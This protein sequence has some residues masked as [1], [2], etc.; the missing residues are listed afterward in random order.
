MLRVNIEIA[1]QLRCVGK[2]RKRPAAALPRT[3][4]MAAR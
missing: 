2:F 4:P 3:L 1:M